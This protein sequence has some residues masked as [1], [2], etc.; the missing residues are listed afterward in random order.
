MPDRTRAIQQWLAARGLILQRAG[1]F[2]N[3][4]YSE[5]VG[6][7]LPAD[8]DESSVQT[9]EAVWDLTLTTPERIASLCAATE[10]VTS[11]GIEGAI[12]ECGVWKGGSMMAVAL[13][14]KRLNHERDIYLYDTYGGMSRPSEMDRYW[15]GRRILDDWNYEEEISGVG[16]VSLDEVRAN[17]ISTGYPEHRLHFVPGLVE[18]TIPDRAPDKIAILRLDT[19]WYESTKHELEHLYPRLVPGGVMIIDD[20]GE[21]QGSRAAVDEYFADEP[22]LLNRIDAASRLVV[23]H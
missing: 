5:R 6:R 9:I 1:T 19:D 7:H 15:T 3:Y 11:R 10:Y 4:R 17:L 14:L 12:V 13:T 22:V 20:Y 21:F 8:F 16:A 23:K 2:D 18:K